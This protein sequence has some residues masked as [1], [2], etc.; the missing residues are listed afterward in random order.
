MG[1]A[2]LA[3]TRKREMIAPLR[4]GLAIAALSAAFTAKAAIGSTF[5][6]VISGAQ[7]AAQSEP[8]NHSEMAIQARDR[9]DGNEAIRLQRIAIEERDRL[10]PTMFRVRAEARNF[11]GFLYLENGQCVQALTPFDEAERLVSSSSPALDTTSVRSSWYEEMLRAQLGQILTHRCFRDFR[12]AFFTAER[13]IA[14]FYRVPLGWDIKASIYNEIALVHQDAGDT[15]AALAAL[16]QGFALLEEAPE[17][18]RLRAV[19][20]LRA[21]RN[22]IRGNAAVAPGRRE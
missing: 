22:R 10:L 7:A 3:G 17:A 1:R 9:G 15:A 8:P 21:T 5:E 2:A 14:N 4:F 19:P 13:A 16:E 6:L 20:R 11:L 18:V 12:A